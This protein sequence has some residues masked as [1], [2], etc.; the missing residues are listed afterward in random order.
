MAGPLPVDSFVREV[1]VVRE[2][3]YTFLKVNVLTGSLQ[4]FGPDVPLNGPTAV[5]DAA[6][7]APQ[8]RGLRNW[9]RF[10]SFEVE[11]VA[12][13]YRVHIRDVRY[14]RFGARARSIGVGL[15]ELDSDLRPR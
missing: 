14:S 6:L 13:G 12:D 10:P 2:D 8:V 15:V 11:Q 7:N 1:I 9:L 4:P 3:R 5:T